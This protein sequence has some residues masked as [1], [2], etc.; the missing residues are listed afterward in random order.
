MVVIPRL[1]QDVHVDLPSIFNADPESPNA[2]EP[3]TISIPGPNE[4]YYAENRY[5]LEG[6]MT[7][8]GAAHAS[9][10]LRRLALRADAD[11]R[12]VEMREIQRRFQELGFP[13][14]S[15]LITQKHRWDDSG[16]K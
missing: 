10:P 9:E 8:M 2:G 11:L 15:F 6:I 14:S 7:A 1:N 12:Y 13:G 3:F 5:D 4:F 16:S